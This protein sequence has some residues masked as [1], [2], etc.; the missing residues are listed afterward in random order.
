MGNYGNNITALVTAGVLIYVDE[1]AAEQIEDTAFDSRIIADRDIILDEFAVDG[2]YQPGVLNREIRAIPR[3]VSDD[4]AN[5][6][7]SRHRSPR[8]HVKVPND[9]A[10]G[11]TADEFAPG[12]KISIP[13]RKGAGARSFGLLRIVKQSAAFVTYEAR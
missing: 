1:P 4:M 13:P 3:Y 9:P 5:D 12:Q 11:I 7:A 2:I 10:D 6:P 8:L